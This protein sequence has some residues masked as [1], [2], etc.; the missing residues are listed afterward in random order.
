MTTFELEMELS[1]TS[2][3]KVPSVRLPFSA[4]YLL[5]DRIRRE[6]GV[7]YLLAIFPRVC[8]VLSDTRLRRGE[9]KVYQRVGIVQFTEHRESRYGMDWLHGA[10]HCEIMIKLKT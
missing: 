5:N 8:L 2:S 7:L 3:C 10:Q 6:Q 1:E 9:L 4:D